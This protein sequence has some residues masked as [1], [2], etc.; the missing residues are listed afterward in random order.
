ML[1]SGVTQS[2]KALSSPERW[3]ANNMASL[4]PSIVVDNS[5]VVST[6]DPVTLWG[7]NIAY[8]YPPLFFQDPAVVR[9]AQ[10][11]GFYF[12][13]IPGG[14]NTDVYHWNGNGVRRPD[15]SI[16]PAA[17][18]SDGSWA[19][20]FSRFAPGFEVRGEA[21]TADPLFSSQPDFGHVNDFDHSPPVDV[22]A[23]ATWVTKL[24]PQAQMMMDVNVGTASRLTATGPNNTLQESDVAAGAQ[25]AAA[26]VRYFNQKLGLHVKYWEIGNE[27]NPYGAEVG[28]H[29]RDKSSQGWHWITAGDYATILRKYAHDMKA[30]DPSIKIAGPVGYLSAFGDASGT[31]SWISTFLQKAGDVVDVVDIHFYNSGP[32][33]ADTVA[34]PAELQSNVDQIRGW[35]AQY[36]PARANA[37]SVGVSEWGDYNNA[38]PIGD[39]LYAADL[40][41]QMAQTQL[42]FGNAWDLDNVIPDNGSPAPSFG[43]DA[44]H[45]DTGGWSAHPSSGATN[46]LSWTADPNYSR[47]GGQSLIVDYR[48]STGPNDGLGHDLAGT[49]V[50]P[51]ASSLA[52]DVLVPSYPGNNTISFWLR[53][54]RA[55]GSVDDSGRNQPQRP[56]WGEWDHLLLPLDPTA[57]HGARRID[58]VVDSNLPIVSPVYISNLETQKSFRQPNGRYWAAYMYHHYFSNTLLATRVTGISRDLFAAY[59]SRSPDGTMYLMVV[60]KDSNNDVTVPIS[61]TGYQP[62]SSGQSYTWSQSNYQWDASTGR[63]D[64]DTPPTNST[65]STGSNFRYVFPKYSITAIKLTPA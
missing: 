21:S 28:V 34:K 65:I 33:E 26:L 24:G 57:L 64:K 56:I 53:I 3:H 18:R 41:G 48:G 62:A 49:S 4:S 1:C 51:A 5:K 58:V 35:L 25:E 46:N 10:D 30:V 43:F 60:N 42:A 37:I 39:A 22:N 8:Y 59:A 32:T 13:R 47:P 15:G 7:N 16:N 55:D 54:E 29:V 20:D 50:N 17:R 11:A 23:L 31:T 9:L 63:A 14:L 2:N 61:I 40:M 45:R 12:F 27:L 19:I 36:A 44:S 52:V 38:Y 6:F